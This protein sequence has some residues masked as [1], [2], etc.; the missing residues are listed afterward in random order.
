MIEVYNH[1]YTNVY[2]W[3]VGLR[4]FLQKDYQTLLY[5]LKP[6]LILQGLPILTTDKPCLD[7]SKLATLLMSDD[8]PKFSHVSPQVQPKWTGQWG[9]TLIIW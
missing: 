2:K 8:T 5:E 4:Y 6:D 7:Y 1:L 9:Q 3:S